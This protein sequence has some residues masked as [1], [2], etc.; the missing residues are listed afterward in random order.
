MAAS[1]GF[2]EVDRVT[3]P[4]TCICTAMTCLNEELHNI[5]DCVTHYDMACHT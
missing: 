4:E 2:C 3:A 5:S 1:V